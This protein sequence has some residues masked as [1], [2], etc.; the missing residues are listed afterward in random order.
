MIDFD[1]AG[2]VSRF[3]RVRICWRYR[4]CVVEGLILY[5]V[6]YERNFNDQDVGLLFK[7]GFRRIVEKFPF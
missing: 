3:R 5:S 1:K 7:Q 4:V 2:I 6:A